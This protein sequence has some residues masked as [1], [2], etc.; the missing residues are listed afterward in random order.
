MTLGQPLGQ[1]LGTQQAQGGADAEMRL[2]GRLGPEYGVC[3]ICTKRFRLDADTPAAA[4]GTQVVFAQNGQ[5]LCECG[6]K[7]R[8][9]ATPVE[10]LARPHGVLPRLTRFWVAGR[11]DGYWGERR[12]FRPA[13]AERVGATPRQVRFAY[14]AGLRAGE[15]LRLDAQAH[16]M[17]VMRMQA[18][19]AFAAAA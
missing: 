15:R 12:F 8:A 1:P 16:R 3:L 4:D 11:E 18:R 9:Y 5:P 14:Q 17:R 2:A 13:A 19:A 7:L 6:A 10:L